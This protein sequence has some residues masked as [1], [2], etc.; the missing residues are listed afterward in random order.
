MSTRIGYLAEPPPRCPG[1]RVARFLLLLLAALW[2]GPAAHAARGD[3]LTA[4]DRYDLGLKYMRRGYYVKALE[5][6]NHLRNYER[7]DPYAVLAEIAIADLHF[8]KAEFD[9]AR[10]SYEDFL[11]LHPRH[12]KADYATWR[13]GLCLWRKAPS[14]AARDQTWTRQA[15]D[16]WSGFAVRYPQ[17]GYADEVKE[18]LDA[19]RARLAHKELIIGR[20]YFRR[21]A[22][23][24][25]AGR[26]RGLLETW[27][28]CP[29]AGLARAL[30]GQA[31]V[32]EGDLAGA[33]A[34]MDALRA[35]PPGD[36]ATR[37][38]TDRL[39]RMLDVP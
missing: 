5:Q 13:M 3:R 35:A 12:D 22:W 6:F 14:I 33:R 25:A 38:E 1:D 24:A 31:L 29:D 32:H 9:Q 17:S 20:F 27:P 39:M 21:G 15:V 8:K 7:D 34:A 30:L 10:M 23:K 36:H 19:G 26:F 28:Y 18:S 2:L 4:E 11:R 16:V 37:R